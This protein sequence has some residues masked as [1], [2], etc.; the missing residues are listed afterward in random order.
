MLHVLYDLLSMVL[1]EHVSYFDTYTC[2]CVFEM[3]FIQ[4]SSITQE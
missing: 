4:A 1:D 3:T 2:I